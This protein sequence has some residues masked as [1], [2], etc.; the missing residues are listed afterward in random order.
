MTDLVEDFIREISIAEVRHHWRELALIP[1]LRNT[2]GDVESVPRDGE[3][4]L[5]LV[6]TGRNVM[7][8]CAP[9]CGDASIGLTSCVPSQGLSAVIGTSGVVVV[10][11]SCL[12]VR[13]GREVSLADT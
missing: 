2:G 8:K 4:I 13:S 7:R 11:D 1:A 12:I 9:L 5:T 6:G 10:E 3:K